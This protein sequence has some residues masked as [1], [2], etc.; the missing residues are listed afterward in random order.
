MFTAE[1]ETKIQE[2]IDQIRQSDIF[3]NQEYLVR[4]ALKKGFF[5]WE[6]VEI[7][8]H[9]QDEEICEWYN[10]SKWLCA[11]LREVGAIVLENDCG[12]FWGRTETGQRLQ[13]DNDLKNVAQH[14]LGID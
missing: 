10:V 1:Q 6:D 5:L 11:N 8:R 14:L 4:E 12:C 2:K 7:P 3:C 9:A 13:Y